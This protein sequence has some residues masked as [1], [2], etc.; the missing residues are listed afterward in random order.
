MLRPSSRNAFSKL[1]TKSLFTKNL[2]TASV[3]PYV[4]DKGLPPLFS[5]EA[6]H[7]QYN[8]RIPY[9]LNKVDS[10]AVG[11][12]LENKPLKD[13]V[14]NTS[15][16]PEHAVIYNNASQAWN[17]EFFLKNLTDRPSEP[18]ETLRVVIAK[19]FGSFD[20]FKN[21]F[22][23]YARGI[24]GNGWTW[25]LLDQSKNL[26][27][28]NTYNAGSV[29]S[30]LPTDVNGLISVDSKEALNM[31][32]RRSNNPSAY[33][34]STHASIVP[35]LNLNMW[36]D[37]YFTDFKYDR[38]SYIEAFWKTVDWRKLGNKLVFGSSN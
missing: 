29:F 14:V 38:D 20:N 21:I 25:L 37:S 23:S 13:I 2:H 15:V 5:A 8:V 17:T 16:N 31:I 7:Y 34:H 12:G 35:V 28:R 11:T 24:F 36:V 4:L 19:Q 26:Y 9:L 32:L 18:D 22:S 1:K 27:I 10:F 6:L 3:L 30:M 33:P